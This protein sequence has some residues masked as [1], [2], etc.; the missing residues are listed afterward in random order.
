MQKPKR[1]EAVVR[2]MA[3]QLTCPVTV[4]LRMGYH[5]GINTAHDVLASLPSWGAS[6]STLHGRSRQQ[7]YSVVML[8]MA[9][10]A[11]LVSW[12]LLHSTLCGFVHVARLAVESQQSLTSASWAGTL[13]RQTG[14][15][16]ASVR[17]ASAQTC[18]SSATA[19]CSHGRSMR[20]ACR[21]RPSWQLPWWRVQP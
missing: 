12:D 16:L 18:S 5:T 8:C 19:T 10:C 4:K 20:A 13:G 1:L 11:L 7:R 6:A 14:S 2:G 15:T 21:Q 9:A 3:A 17:A